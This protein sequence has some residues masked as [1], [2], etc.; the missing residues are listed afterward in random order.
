M[1][2]IKKN[3]FYR[4][5]PNQVDVGPNKSST[6]DWLLS[7]TRDGTKQ[8]APREL[9]H[10]LNSLRE[11]QVKRLEIGEAEPE[12]EQLFARSSF[13]D[14]L[15]EVSKVRL[16]CSGIGDEFALENYRFR[17][18]VRVLRF[19]PTFGFTSGL[20]VRRA[21]LPPIRRQATLSARSTRG[22]HSLARSFASECVRGGK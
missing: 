16:D 18:L 4:L 7:R 9:I 8:N 17:F 22:P 12:G 2:Q 13:K 3:M 21:M 1:S 11:V 19:P 20:A 15:P 5:Y 14:A 6:F 10:F